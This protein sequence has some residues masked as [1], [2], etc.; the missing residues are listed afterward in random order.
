MVVLGDPDDFNSAIDMAYFGQGY[1]QA[2]EDLWGMEMLR[3]RASGQDPD[4]SDSLATIFDF[5]E[6]AERALDQMSPSLQ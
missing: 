4:N 6:L 2:K 3:R 1:Q 5:Y